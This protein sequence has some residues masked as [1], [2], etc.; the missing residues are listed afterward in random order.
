MQKKKNKKLENKM[1]NKSVTEVDLGGNNNPKDIV[2]NLVGTLW[3]TEQKESWK[4]LCSYSIIGEEICPDTG[5]THWQCFGELNKQRRLNG[6]WKM[7]PNCFI[8]GCRDKDAAIIYCKKDGKWEE[9]GEKKAQGTRTDLVELIKEIKDG[10]K[11]IEIYEEDPVKYLLNEKK[12]GRIRK[13]EGELTMENR[14]DLA[15]EIYVLCGKTGSGKTRYVRE[16]CKNLY[17]M[18]V[19]ENGKI[20]I[21]GYCGEEDV[22][23]DEYNGQ[24]A[25][26]SFL[27][28]TDRYGDTLAIKGGFL[29]FKPLRIW[30]C[31]NLGPDDWYPDAKAEEKKAMW[32]RF[33]DVKRF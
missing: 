29:K 19:F 16:N 6:I 3:T 25:I 26:Q 31:S 2:R 7:I 13:M 5:K 32:R 23:I 8:R 27:R 22:L 12:I 9:F 10:K 18:P 14:K 4:L 28:I 15:T 30:I 24:L 33:T 17:I 20:W 11:D 1:C 21:D